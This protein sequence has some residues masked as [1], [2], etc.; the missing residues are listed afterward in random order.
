MRSR[1][2]VSMSGMCSS[3]QSARR[4]GAPKGGEEPSVIVL[5]DGAP[6]RR[7]GLE[8]ASELT[9]RQANARIETTHNDRTRLHSRSEVVVRSPNELLD[10]VRQKKDG[11]RALTGHAK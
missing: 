7:Y 8:T 2:F 9:R 6:S 5:A 3:T 10:I 11:E 1:V 4:H